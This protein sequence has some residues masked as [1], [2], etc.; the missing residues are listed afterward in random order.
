MQWGYWISGRSRYAAFTD[1]ELDDW[2][3]RAAGVGPVVVRTMSAGCQDALARQGSGGRTQRALAVVEANKRKLPPGRL[4]QPWIVWEGHLRSF[5]D[6]LAL[7]ESIA[8]LCRVTEVDPSWMV[9]GL[10]GPSAPPAVTVSR[11]KLTGGLELNIPRVVPEGW[12]RAKKAA[13]AIGVGVVLVG[14]VAL[15]AR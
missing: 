11:A 7:D 13:V 12:S 8:T 3:R 14:V 1:V 10:G 2:H 6:A 5:L 15:V 9:A 4:S